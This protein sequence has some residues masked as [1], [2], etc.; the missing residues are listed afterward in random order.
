MA[1][2]PGADPNRLF[3]PYQVW[4]SPTEAMDSLCCPSCTVC[5][6]Q[7]TLLRMRLLSN[8]N[9]NMY[10]CT[11][12]MYVYISTYNIYIYTERER[13]ANMVLYICRY[14]HLWP[15]FVCF[16]LGVLQTYRY[17]T[18]ASAGRERTGCHAMQGHGTRLLSILCMACH[19]GRACHDMQRHGMS[20]HAMA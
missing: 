5:R 11:V 19:A 15:V 13:Y 3:L 9:N 8:S 20:P 1:Q 14:V 2:A 7:P 10:I 12:C 6:Q 4:V 18:S 16:A 17:T